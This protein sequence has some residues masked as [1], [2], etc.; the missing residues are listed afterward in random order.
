M[1]RRLIAPQSHILTRNTLQ[2][3]PF[4][5]GGIQLRNMRKAIEGML[6]KPEVSNILAHSLV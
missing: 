6:L 5:A 1:W 4:T 2:I 3:F